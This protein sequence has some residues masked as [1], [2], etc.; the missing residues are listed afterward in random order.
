MIRFIIIVFVTTLFFFRGLFL[1]DPDFGW[2]VRMGQVILQSGIPRTDPF[3]YTMPSYPFVDH[4][5]LTNIVI[6]FLYSH[7]GMYGLAIIFSLLTVFALAISARFL[8][9][10]EA[11]IFFLIG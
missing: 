4:E 1:L 7:V 11:T 6:A 3:S 5:W 10:T 8:R 9:T 2:H